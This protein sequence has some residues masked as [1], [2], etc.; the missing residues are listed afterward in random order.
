MGAV[1]LWAAA[2]VR[3]R[4]PALLLLAV[5]VALP[6][7]AVLALV[8]G[9][10]RADSSVDRFAEATELADVVM[11]M[12]DD[13][14]AILEE[15]AA[16]ARVRSVQQSL[17]VVAVPE[18]VPWGQFGFSLIGVDG[19]SPGGLGPPM[20]LD[21]RLPR[22]GSTDEI[23]VNERAAQAHGFEVG[24]RAG[25][26][27]V[28]S[29][30]SFEAKPLGD[31]H[32][33][34]IV[35]LVFDLVDDPSSESFAIS[36]PSLLDGRWREA[37]TIGSI[38]WVQLEDRAD[39]S[40][41]LSDYSQLIARG[42]V[43][44]TEGILQS[45]RRAVSLQHGALLLA[46]VVVG[47]TGLVAIFQAVGRHLAP[48]REDSE[49]LAAMG[50][51]PTEQWWAAVLSVVPALAGGA[52]FGLGVAVLCSPLLPFGLARRA[53]PDV[54]FHADWLVLGVGS[55]V[56]ALLLAVAA[57]LATR[58]LGERRTSSPARPSP[59][60]R[61]VERTGLRPVPAAGVQL[62]T[63][64]GHGRTRLPVVPTLVVLVLTAAIAAAALIVRSSVDGLTADAERYGQPWDVLVAG[65]EG[66]TELSADPR[67]E[68]VD[69]GHT[70]E[71]NIAAS[72][73]EIRQIATTGMA[74]ATGPMW[75]AVLDGH[76]PGGPG[77]IAL[78]TTTLADLDVSVGDRTTISGPCGERQVEVVGR[79]IV[80]LFISD[81]P[82][83]GSVM[84]LSTFDELCAD[85]LTAE[86][87]ENEGLAVR[88][89]DPADAPALIDEMAAA[90]RFAQPLAPKPGTVTTL[91][92]LRG[93]PVIVVVTIGALGVFA[94]AHALLLALRRRRGDLAVLR[95]LGMRPTDIRRVVGWQ[96]I[97]MT[98]VAVVLGLP[99]GL[100]IGRLVWATIAESSN[101]L[102]H[103]D[104][105]PLQ[106]L[107]LASGLLAVLIT[108][109]LWPAH[110]AGRLRPADALRTE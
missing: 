62:A 74:G 42:D 55:M 17:S 103:V 3:R 89:H 82:D 6:V 65:R 28:E 52:L 84:A 87:D 64:S 99:A 59:V 21:G 32:V 23:L 49:V 12:E 63:S 57:G 97:T 104:V 60:A 9:S 108:L 46:A 8:A 50:L 19:S 2:D 31:V 76:A 26:M 66:A 22:V 7:G 13:P 15:L 107:L 58:R 43:L 105:A 4:W 10:R 109:S 16:D 110:R 56:G 94:A 47:V 51:T 61:L 90:E 53:D 44:G 1:W 29:M 77:E 96:A 98:I 24:D 41:L 48:R 38:L 86:I 85:Q 20:L 106:L 34:G 80:P 83:E 75:L 54:G 33:V 25:M 92:E 11:F 68:G 72:A 71:V 101:V 67:V 27:G 40:A 102:V 93:V 73:G 5:L 100:V 37:A 45:A 69:V 95:V 91:A 39:Q 36:G 30:E 81:D 78:G 79:T 18:P 14:A 70:G 88:L 35:R